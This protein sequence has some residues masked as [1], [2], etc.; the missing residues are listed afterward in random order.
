MNKSSKANYLLFL[1]GFVIAIVL[2]LI[3]SGYNDKKLLD[4]TVIVNTSSVKNKL[5]LYEDQNYNEATQVS[6]PATIVSKD[7]E[8]VIFDKS[9]G[10]SYKSLIVSSPGFAVKF[11]SDLPTSNHAIYVQSPVYINNIERKLKDLAYDSPKRAEYNAVLTEGTAI[12]A[13]LVSID[14]ADAVNAVVEIL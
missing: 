4:F 11:V 2:L 12:F 5:L 14:E 6:V 3:F 13:E 1:L 10:W 8:T 7:D 9:L